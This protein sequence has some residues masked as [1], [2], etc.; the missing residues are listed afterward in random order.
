MSTRAPGIKR[1]QSRLI[2]KNCMPEN[3]EIDFL[4]EALSLTR[5]KKL[6]STTRSEI[7]TQCKV[8]GKPLKCICPKV[9][10]REE[11]MRLIR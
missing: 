8:G 10:S 3:L 4:S 1:V 2:P 9:L 7:G 5:R 11:L 6:F